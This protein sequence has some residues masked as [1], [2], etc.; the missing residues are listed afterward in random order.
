MRKIEMNPRSGCGQTSFFE[1]RVP[2]L[3]TT[4]PPFDGSNYRILVRTP[5]LPESR[6][7]RDIVLVIMLEKRI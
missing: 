6:R 3:S 7:K 5:M 4:L 2:Y 1:G